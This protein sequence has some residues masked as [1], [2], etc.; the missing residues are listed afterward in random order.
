VLAHGLLG[1][2]A[3]LAYGATSLAAGRRVLGL[4]HWS[5]NSALAEYFAAE[6]RNLTPPCGTS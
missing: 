5:R 1:F 4:I 2:V 3:E 6:T